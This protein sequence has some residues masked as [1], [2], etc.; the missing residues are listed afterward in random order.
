MREIW[1]A[2]AETD[3]FEHGAD[4]QPFIWG[5]YNGIEYHEFETTAALV[6]FFRDKKVIVY[7]HNGGRFDWHFLLP[8][9]DAFTPVMIIAGRLAKFSIGECE[10]RDSYNI[11]PSP[12]SAYQKDEIDYS[13]FKRDVRHR[14]MHEIREYLRSDCRYLYEFVRAFIDRYGLN[15]TFASAAMKVWQKIENIEAPTTSRDFYKTFEPYYYGGRVQAFH[16]G[17]IPHAFKVIDINSAYPFAMKHP[18]PYG[19]GYTDGCALEPGRIEQQFISLRAPSLGAF[20]YREPDGSLN[21]PDDGKTREF[22]VT[23]WEFIAAQETGCLH[24]FEL[25]RTLSL[26]LRIRFDKYIDHFFAEKTAAKQS[27]DKAG[28]Q[29]AKYFLNGLYGKFAANPEKYQEYQIID[30]TYIAGAMQDGYDF[31]AP[32]G[33]WALMCRDL[34]EHKQRF[35][36]LA[37]GASITGFVRAYLWRAIRSCGS[38]LYCDTDAIACADTG[39]LELDSERLGAWDVEAE[40]VGGG[41]GGKKLYAF[42]KKDGTYKS[43]S[44]GARLSPAELLRVANGEIVEYLSEAPTFSVHTGRRY[45]SRNVKRKDVAPPKKARRIR[46]A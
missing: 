29:F 17:P 23:G 3:P 18:H 31:S 27:G 4:I 7:A 2:D 42:E 46:A 44:K 28:Y 11:L 38:V 40:C 8:H 14:Y 16:L 36:N 34:S 24:E 35:Y 25:L 12:L 21:F 32:L 13:K 1:V 9:L 45:I 43:A 5:A 33:P 22:H 20:P 41:I 37:V 10:F 39:N 30:P 15:L 6:D 19:N 26:P